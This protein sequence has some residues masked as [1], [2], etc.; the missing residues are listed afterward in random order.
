MNFDLNTVSKVAYAWEDNIETHNLANSKGRLM[1][2]RGEQIG[3]KYNW[4]QSKII[5]TGPNKIEVL[6]IDTK[7]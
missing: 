6:R 3:I 4:F 1:N 2:P 5:P 7:Q